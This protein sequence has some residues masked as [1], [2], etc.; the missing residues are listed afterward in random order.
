MEI[1]S[2]SLPRRLAVIFV[3]FSTLLWGVSTYAAV[4]ID[5]SVSQPVINA[6]QAG[7]KIL[8]SA[9]NTGAGGHV[10]VYLVIEIEGNF[11]SFRG[12]SNWTM[13][14]QAWLPN[15]LLQEEFNLS[16]T[17]VATLPGIGAGTYTVYAAITPPG[18]LQPHYLGQTVFEVVRAP[19]GGDSEI[20]TGFL[21]LSESK[22]YS[23]LGPV[24]TVFAS[25]SFA[26]IRNTDSNSGGVP[27]N[28]FPDV[29]EP[30][31][32]ECAFSTTTS[33]ADQPPVDIDVDITWLDIGPK[34]RLNF[35]RA[36]TDRGGV[37]M[38]MDDDQAALAYIVYSYTLPETLPPAASPT[39][40]VKQDDVMFLAPGGS[41]LDRASVTLTGVGRPDLIS[42]PLETLR[43][44]DTAQ[45]F[46]LVWAA[47]GGGALD[48]TLSGG[49]S[50]FN[51]DSGD[52]SVTTCSVQCRF[53]DDGRAAVPMP[54]LQ[55]LKQCMANDSGFPPTAD[56][57]VSLII[58]RGRSRAFN[59]VSGQLD[60]GMAR[61]SSAVS[62]GGIALD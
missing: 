26:H 24:H 4:A 3:Y 18:S 35:S 53:V 52:F 21:F 39:V 36:G 9:S 62:R 10:D 31:N 41:H 29:D 25:G 33:G 48:V 57:T 58:E 19:E 43:R 17:Q 34:I 47:N 38:L 11:W 60:F 37:D 6:D 23:S 32:D 45:N 55:A 28:P 1:L 44:L 51:F 56:G 20:V 15:Y 30:A 22:A 16:P 8:I 54:K 61:V 40:L 14:I 59:T 2:V 46:D 27:E 12:G 13:G 7:Q 42:P 49:Y 50:S 5:P